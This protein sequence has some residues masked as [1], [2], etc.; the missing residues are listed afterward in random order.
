[1]SADLEWREHMGVAEVG[2]SGFYLSQTG[3]RDG[4]FQERRS[5][6]L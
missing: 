2:H 3:I 5:C 1:L 4:A 6:L